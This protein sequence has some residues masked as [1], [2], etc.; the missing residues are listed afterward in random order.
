MHQYKVEFRVDGHRTETVVSAHGMSEARKL[1]EAM[2]NG[3]DVH[4][5]V[6]HT[7]D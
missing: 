4:V 2:Y 7:L 3:C 6:V 1:V 5:I